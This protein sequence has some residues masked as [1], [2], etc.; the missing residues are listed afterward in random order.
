MISK[1]K[2]SMKFENALDQPS[3]KNFLYRVAAYH[4]GEACFLSFDEYKIISKTPKGCWIVPSWCVEEEYKKFKKFV[5]DRGAKKF[6]YN[7]RDQALKGFY[8]RKRR[9]ITILKTQLGRAI[10]AYE[11]AGGDLRYI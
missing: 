4:T 11:L 7:T 2:K 1:K 10:K 3:D 5:L 6:A 8:F 9:Q